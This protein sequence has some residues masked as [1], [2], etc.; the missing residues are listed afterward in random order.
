MEAR[1]GTGSGA[2]FVA[3]NRFAVLDRTQNAL[4]IKNLLNEVT[5]KVAVP[6]GLAPDSI[7]YAGTGAVLLRGEDRVAMLDLQTRAVVGEVAA[8]QVRWL[9]G[10]DE[11][12]THTQLLTSPH[13]PTSPS[14]VKYVVWSPD[15]SLVA[16]LS[17]HAVV[18]ADRKLKS[19]VTVHETI[20]VKSAAFDASGAL[21]YTTLNH[22]KYCLPNGDS[23]IVRTLDAPLYLVSVQGGQVRGGVGVVRV[24]VVWLGM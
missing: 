12:Q 24:S 20:R 17:K 2:A 10:S 9:R 23:G 4:L 22:M 6:A 1:R 13:L 21:L 3:R 19:S 5:K 16:L 7:F 18:I 8:A 15:M 14:Q 11:T